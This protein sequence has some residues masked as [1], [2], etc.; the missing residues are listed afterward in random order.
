MFQVNTV[1]KEDSVEGYLTYTPG[2]KNEMHSNQK[3]NG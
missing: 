3:K 1:R 2:D